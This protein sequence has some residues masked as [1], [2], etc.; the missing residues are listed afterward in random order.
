MKIIIMRR[1]KEK[2]RNDI[3]MAVGMENNVSRGQEKQVTNKKAK[4]NARKV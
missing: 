4:R 2:K 3:T 1:K